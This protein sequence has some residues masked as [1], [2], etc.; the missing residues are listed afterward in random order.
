MQVDVRKRRQGF[1]LIE[2]LVVVAVIGILGAILTA[3]VNVGLVSA[4][5]TNCRSNLRTL[6]MSLESAF[7]EDLV[8]PSNL[9][10]TDL[11]G[12]QERVAQA[13][14]AGLPLGCFPSFPGLA[15]APMDPS[16]GQHI[17]PTSG[18]AAP[19]APAASMF[20][21]P[22]CPLAE[23]NPVFAVDPQ[24][25]PQTRSFGVRFSMLGESLDQGGWLLAESNLRHIKGP[26]DLAIRHRG[27]VHVYQVGGGVASMT[28][29][30]VD[31]TQP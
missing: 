22:A 12:P 23:L 2:L 30:Q 18:G 8:I 19:R 29:E 4:K 14:Y 31:F 5:E 17:P 1:T 27:K 25:E 21:T 3:A 28:A 7:L 16:T 13:R 24:N 15:P 9:H 20:K 11:D 10:I 6:G 26:E